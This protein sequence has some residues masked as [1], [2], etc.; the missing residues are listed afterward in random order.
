MVIIG[1]VVALGLVVLATR[2]RVSM[3][4]GLLA[5]CVVVALTGGMSADQT[6][7]AVISAWLEPRGLAL[8]AVVG[9]LIIL[10]QLLEMSGRMERL[11]NLVRARIS[12]PRLAMVVFPAL[13]GLLPMPG[14]AV[15]SAPM[16][17]SA[18][19]GC[20]LAPDQK[21]MINYWFRHVWEYAWPLYPVVI[22][23]SSMSGEPLGRL[24][25][26]F[27]PVSLAAIGAGY[28]FIMR[29]MDARPAP[30]PEGQNLEG[31][32]PALGAPIVVVVAGA[33][34]G[35]PLLKALSSTLPWLA[36]LPGQAPMVAALF[37][38]VIVAAIQAGDGR[39]AVRAVFSRHTGA[40]FYL[41]AA[42]LAF[43]AVAAASGGVMALKEMM[44]AL[45][46]PLVVLVVL[47]PFITGLITGLAIGYAATA[48]PVFIGLLPP[49]QL[50]SY[51]LLAHAAGFAGV[52]YSPAHACLA[53]TNGYFGASSGAVYRRLAAPSLLTLA[54]AGA[55]ALALA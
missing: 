6:I 47:L 5:G 23:I 34:I 37:A 22:L 29:G 11:F 16:V 44:V 49:D 54:A 31:S 1:L 35:G 39:L 2:L 9:Q 25:L 43:Q 3:A 41:I 40:M 28:L 27:A 18:A 55:M 8:A 19:R 36:G 24:A 48:F 13:I 52:M 51:L 15:F 26:S 30:P 32:I 42:I 12:S 38:A 17:G 46:L 14:G 50:L 4:H 53:L 10:S 45:H 20:N 21:S 7:R 33:L